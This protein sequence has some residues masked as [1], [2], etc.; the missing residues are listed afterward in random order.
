MVQLHIRQRRLTGKYRLVFKL[1]LN[2][3]QLAGDSLFQSADHILKKREAFR[4]IFIQRITL[5]V[6][7]QMDHLAQIIIGYDMVAPKFIERLQQDRFF[8]LH[9]Q[10]LAWHSLFPVFAFLGINRVHSFRYTFTNLNFGNALF[11]GPFIHRKINGYG[12]AQLFTQAAG[13][14]L[15][16]INIF[17]NVLGY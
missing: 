2:A 6:T 9:L 15:L 13:I 8:N 4:L 17:G 16:G 5:A 7:A 3:Q 12:L 14:P 11:L 10:L 1:Q